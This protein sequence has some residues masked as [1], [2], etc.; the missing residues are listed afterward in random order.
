MRTIDFTPVFRSTVGYDRLAR[1]MDAAYKSADTV[2]S[3]Y[4]PY[5]IEKVG[6]EAYRVT[7]AIAGFTQDD[8]DVTVKENT[9]LVSGQQADVQGSE[10]AVVLHR[11]IANRAFKHRF[12]LADHII[13]TGATLE[14]GM[15]QIDLAREIPEE[16]KPRKI[17]IGST[18][19][20]TRNAA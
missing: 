16:K 5:N 14:H 12:Q 9:L 1:M 18:P 20:L 4:P 11:G 6:D 8:V 15:L 3:S 17:Q 13:V 2:G 7:M 10:N 19:K